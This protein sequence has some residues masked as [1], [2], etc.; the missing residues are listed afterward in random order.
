ML[1][2]P[3]LDRAETAASAILTPT[4][5][6][7]SSHHSENPIWARVHTLPL[8]SQS[9]ERTEACLLSLGMLVWLGAGGER[10]C[11]G[12]GNEG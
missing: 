1:W 5:L 12:G 9:E 10:V 8:G 4:S 7:I 3:M 2:Y 11:L 6:S